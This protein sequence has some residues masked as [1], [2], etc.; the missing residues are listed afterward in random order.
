MKNKNEIWVVEWNVKYN[1]GE[2][3][4]HIQRLKKT[5]KLNQN[6]F[7]HNSSNKNELG[8]WVIIAVANSR[9]AA[10][11]VLDEMISQSS[12]GKL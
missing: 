3:Q 7:F 11:R 5:V 4:Y 6:Y 1:G 10:N 12:E 2:K 8:Q 9:L